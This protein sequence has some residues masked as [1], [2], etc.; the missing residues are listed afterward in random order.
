MLISATEAGS[1]MY[2]S[3]VTET[4]S[5]KK[6][7]QRFTLALAGNPNSGKSSLFN[8]LTGLNQKI[9]N[10][11]GVTVD[12][13]VGTIR[14][15]NQSDVTVI[16]FPGTY[17]LYPNS[18]DER[19]VVQTFVNPKD[20]NFPDAILYIADITK[21]EQHLL[22]LTQLLDLDIPIILV[23]NMADL[24]EQ[25]GLQVNTEKIAEYFNIPVVQMSS[26]SGEGKDQLLK[27]I[28]QLKSQQGPTQKNKTF[29]IL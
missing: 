28:E 21:I 24:A 8:L 13:K 20:P 19:I 14:L 23:L 4:N 11:P 9:G 2:H 17:S 5:S 26:R 7:N 25:G 6:S 15:S 1:S 16:D 22:L 27:A 29:F 12:K 3:E 18:I 10:F